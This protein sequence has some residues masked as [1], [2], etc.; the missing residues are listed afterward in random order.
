MRVVVC[1]YT[2]GYNSAPIGLRGYFQFLVGRDGTVTQFAEVDAVCWHAGEWNVYGPGIEVEYRD[3]PTIFTDPQRAACGGLVGWLNSEW[4][5]PLDYYDGPRQS[6]SDQHGFMSHRSLVQTEQHYDF[7]PVE[8][9]LAMIP[10]NE[11]EVP[12]MRI[13]KGPDG[14]FWITDGVVKRYIGNPDEFT[15][16][17]TVGVPVHEGIAQSVLDTIPVWSAGTG[18]SG[19]F[20]LTGTIAGTVQ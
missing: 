7:W 17:A 3:E 14:A 5:V 10:P 4:G 11:P 9:W 13:L 20:T 18:G 12:D 15:M 1:H 8:D 19:P 16:W 6:P 2:V